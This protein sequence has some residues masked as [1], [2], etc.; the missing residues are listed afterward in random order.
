ML[1]ARD[2]PGHNMRGDYWMEEPKKILS[3]LMSLT[4]RE[5]DKVREYI[6]ELKREGQS[7]LRKRM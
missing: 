2:M 3:D 5:L 6:K 7:D 4:E 1:A